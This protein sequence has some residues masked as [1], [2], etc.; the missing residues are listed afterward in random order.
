LPAIP[1]SPETFVS[2]GEV[3]IGSDRLTAVLKLKMREQ[4]AADTA[5]NADCCVH[6]QRIACVEKSEKIIVRCG[7]SME[8]KL[9]K[10]CVRAPRFFDR[11]DCRESWCVLPTSGS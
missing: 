7:N 10:I 6:S 9:P 5:L 11:R 3:R 8:L 2:I 4:A 1:A